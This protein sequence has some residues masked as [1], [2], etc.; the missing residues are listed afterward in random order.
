MNFV[1]KNKTII[2]TIV[3]VSVT[4]IISILGYILYKK[5]IGTN[6]DILLPTFIFWM[7]SM[8]F[9]L[10]LS[11]DSRVAIFTRNLFVFL[12]MVLSIYTSF[13]S[14]LDVAKSQQC[15]KKTTIIEN[16]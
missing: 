2:I 13:E 11:N 1:D 3:L 16:L 14:K 15:T 4:I 7:A 12:L 10:S 6:I 8:I 5:S 9:L